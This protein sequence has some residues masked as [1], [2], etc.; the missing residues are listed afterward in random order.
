MPKIL[1]ITTNLVINR[2]L[3]VDLYNYLYKQ[4][5]QLW[6]SLNL[7]DKIVF[8]LRMFFGH[9]GLAIE[10]VIYWSLT[11]YTGEI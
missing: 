4:L 9:F 5:I 10:V 8:Y 6:D 2:N 7:F 1:F 3:H 11:A